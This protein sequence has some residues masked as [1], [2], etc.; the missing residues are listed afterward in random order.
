MGSLERA[1]FVRA[2]Q[3][4]A[5]RRTDDLTGKRERTRRRILGATFKLIGHERGLN[6]RIEEICALAEASRGTF[7]NYFSSTDELYEALALDLSHDFN[8]ALIKTLESIESCAM[9]ANAAIQHYLRRAR[10]DSA[11]GW[12]MAH[13][14]A[15]GPFFGAESYEACYV[16]IEQGIKE[17]E[18]DV[19]HPQYGRDLLMGAVLAAMVTTLR[20]GGAKTQPRVIAHHVLR[21]LGVAER[22]AREIAESPLPEINLSSGASPPVT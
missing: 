6:T 1:R 5:R 7:Y 10:R 22:R 14:S 20:E 17:G 11:W 13:L 18:F 12:A 8:T 16:T 15:M 9:R 21:A 3:G 4:G 2:K 19:P